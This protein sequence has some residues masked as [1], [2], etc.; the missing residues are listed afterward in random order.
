MYIYIPKGSC[1]KEGKR[2]LG[3]RKSIHKIVIFK[4]DKINTVCMHSPW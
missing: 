2:G 4:S 3:E 1:P